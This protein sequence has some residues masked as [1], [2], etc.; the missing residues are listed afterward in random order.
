MR[1]QMFTF[2]FRTF[3]WLVAF[4]VF[5]VA[6]RHP[7]AQGP[8]PQPPQITIAPTVTPFAGSGSKVI[9]G[10]LLPWYDRDG[11]LAATLG[12]G[13][14]A[15]GQM[16]YAAANFTVT[17]D[18]KQCDV[19]QGGSV[20]SFAYTYNHATDPFKFG[21]NAGLKT[22]NILVTYSGPGGSASKTMPFDLRI[23]QVLP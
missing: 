23:Y 10:T 1:R 13:F 14:Q 7:A 2:S 15:A 4:L 19:S 20:N 9:G 8:P 6:E 21:P 22:L 3:L 18:G 12:G 11:N 17:V 5:L 16:T